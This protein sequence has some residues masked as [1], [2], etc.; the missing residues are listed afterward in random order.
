[1]NS[2]AVRLPAA[3]LI[4][5]HRPW[6]KAFLPLAAAL[7][8]PGLPALA[9][10]LTPGNLT[11]YRIGTGAGS[12]VVTGNPV[13]LDEY[14]PAGALVQ[15]IAL[16]ET[17]SGL[18]KQLI[19]SGTSTSEGMMTR[20]TDG[21]H[22]IMTGYAV[23]TGGAASLSGTASAAVP[24][25]VGRIDAL[26]G[27][28][29]STALTDFSNANNPRGATSTNGNDIWVTGAAGGVRFTT[30]GATTSTQISTTLGNIKGV[31]IYG[32]QMYVSTSNGSV[33][34]LGTVGTGV[35]SIAGQTITNL[36]GFPLTG[37]PYAFVFADLDAA[38]P[39]VDTLYV[40]D[41]TNSTGVGGIQKYA[42]VGSS[43]T[44]KGVAGLPADAYRG[45]AGSVTGSTVTLYAVRKGG[46]TATGGG[47]IVS[48]VD[49]S[50]YNAT[51]TGTPT[52]LA[53]A[54]ANTALRGIALAPQVSPDLSVSVSGPPSAGVGADFSY[55]LIVANG[56]SADASGV[57]VQFTL[58]AG[59]TYSS[60]SGAGFTVSEASGVV[61]FTDGA[62]P[63]ASSKTLTV[64]VS[65]VAPGTFTV[66]GWA[67]VVD[68]AG[69][70]TE[71]DEGNNKSPLPVTTL[72]SL[73]PDL[74]VGL[75][76]PALAVKDVPFDY[77]LTVANGGLGGATGVS[78][79]FTLPAGVSFS[80]G[81]GAGFTVSESAGVVTF[82]GGSL[83]AGSSAVLT[84]TGVA[85]P[86]VATTFTAAASAA[87]IDPLNTVEE[88]NETNNA[89][90]AAVNTLVRL[91][92]LPSAT[93][94]NYTTQ[95]D[96]PLTVNA[97]SG[98][99]ANDPSSARSVVNVSTPAHGTVT[100][101]PDGSFTYT[102]ATGYTGV[103]TFTYTVT[104]AVKLYRHNQPPLGTF[105][106]VPVTGDGYGSAFVPVPG[107]TDEF[108]GLSD[109]GPNV[110]G[111]TDTSKVFPLPNFTPAIGRFKLVNNELVLQ[112]SLITFKTPAGIPYSGRFNSA[113]P[114]LDQGFDINGNL[115]PTDPN[116]FDS[117]GLVAM[118]D[119]T[120]WVS[121]E[122]GPFITHF[123]ATGK[124]L[125]RLS[126]FNGGLPIEFARRV[127]NR[128]MEGLA[129]TPDGTKLVGVLQ[130]GLEQPDNFEQPANVPAD[131]TKVAPV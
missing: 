58:P 102:P 126:P 122:Y 91:Y 66:P 129:L 30:L 32:G 110:D 62:L 112:G 121:D 20:S 103:D 59:V 81:T 39:G 109:R 41:D 125:Q 69:T 94:D 77:T 31:T 101:N 100:T 87:V 60:A 8:L 9:A 89:S 17:A 46:S 55:T 85:S 93:G 38:T 95:T 6:H 54:V 40:V 80:S 4:T 49:S 118:P 63:A 131:A 1:M 7:A 14:S 50:G 72:A 23:N 16:P 117:E 105:G 84:V 79:R 24:R 76:G 2:S 127:S 124:E 28:D 18:Q 34:R 12:L 19:A 83:D 26:G 3:C 90:T 33:I 92:P 119:G 47:E 75:S 106:G 111:L 22:I 114:G 120:F 61:S 99:L 130:S 37:S 68:P 52:L 44:A 35:P 78:V 123:D 27:V 51:L 53:T 29:T 45:L 116:G 82:S 57:N 64:T 36:P 25:T 5:R 43:W 42:L 86:A 97:A 98:L 107:T 71:V 13:F 67:A 96:A 113:N 74:T 115:L 56:G 65:P 108:Y 11:V 104:D 88:T 73:V 70:I 15:S 10:P 21:K 128:G 48:L